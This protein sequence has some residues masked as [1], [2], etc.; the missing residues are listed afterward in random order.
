VCGYVSP[1]FLVDCGVESD[2]E[3]YVCLLTPDWD[4]SMTTQRHVKEF[5]RQ[6]GFGKWTTPEIRKDAIPVLEVC[7]YEYM[8]VR[9]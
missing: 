6:W 1:E 9:P 8:I 5:L 3:E 7:D 2:G 4:Y